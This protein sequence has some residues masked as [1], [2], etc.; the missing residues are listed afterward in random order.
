[1]KKIFLIFACVCI[2]LSVTV[3]C[4]S[5]LA[6]DIYDRIDYYSPHNETVSFGEVFYDHIDPSDIMYGISTIGSSRFSSYEYKLISNF[7]YVPLDKKEGLRIAFRENEKTYKLTLQHRLANLKNSRDEFKDRQTYTPYR[8]RMF[9][10]RNNLYAIV[11]GVMPEN[12]LV[13]ESSK[14]I[15]R[16]RIITVDAVYRCEN[17]PLEVIFEITEEMK[18]YFAEEFDL[19]YLKFTSRLKQI[20]TP[21]LYDM[22]SFMR[23]NYKNF[24]LAAV[25]VM[26]LLTIVLVVIVKHRLKVGRFGRI[27][28]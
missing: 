4:A 12:L 2:F 21:E 5:A 19:V 9:V 25:P 22:F 10:Y 17:A 28:T 20:V 1:M 15:S 7:K 16:N 24:V 13:R 3:G 26:V 14:N 18:E 27:E 8:M 6:K 23:G 11:T